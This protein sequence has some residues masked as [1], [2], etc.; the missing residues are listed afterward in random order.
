MRIFETTFLILAPGDGEAAK[1]AGGIF[2]SG[3]STGALSFAAVTGSGG[4]AGFQKA[5]GFKGFPGAGQKVKP[6]PYSGLS[7][8]T[9]SFHS[10]V[11]PLGSGPF[12][13]KSSPNSLNP[14]YSGC[15]FG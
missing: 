7:F 6:R 8:R 2:G 13:C 12:Q 4:S 9:I 14:L 1:P 10:R 11:M 3:T 15:C 5:E